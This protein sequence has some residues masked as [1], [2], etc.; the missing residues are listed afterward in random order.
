MIY[1]I[2]CNG[3]DFIKFGR[4]KDVGRR[5]IEL[6]NANPH[7]L[8]IAVTASWHDGA[9]YAIHRF[10][11]AHRVKNEWFEDCPSARLVMAWML[12]GDRGL[13]QLQ[14]ASAQVA[15]QRTKEQTQERERVALRHLNSA[16]TPFDLTAWRA[17]RA[18]RKLRRAIASSGVNAK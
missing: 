5:L 17:D 7:E 4:A 9:E 6:D 8:S 14:H 2:R 1:A 18:A 12:D 3:T 16:R 10:L 11:A 15:R 13:E